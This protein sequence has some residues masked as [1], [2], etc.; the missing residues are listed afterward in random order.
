MTTS[1]R[2]EQLEDTVRDIY[3]TVQES[4]TT[5]ADMESA[6]DS[7]AELCTDSIPDLNTSEPEEDEETSDDDNT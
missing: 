5:R 4:G 1:T 2:T 7:I 6:L 3:D